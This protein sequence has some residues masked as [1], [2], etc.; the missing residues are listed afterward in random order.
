ME[1]LTATTRCGPKPLPVC[2]ALRCQQVL[3][4]GDKVE[5]SLYGALYHTGCLPDYEQSVQSGW[6]NHHPQKQEVG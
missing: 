4:H 5:R 3:E 6:M 2:H 1:T